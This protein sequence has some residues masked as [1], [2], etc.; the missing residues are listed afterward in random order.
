MKKL[1]VYDFPTRVFHWCF[2]GLFVSAFFIAKNIDDD[3]PLYPYHML[4]GISL[5]A[6]VLLRFIWGIWGSKHAKFTDFDLSP[7]NLMG[8]L[9]GILKGDK[10]TWPGHNPASSWAALMMILFALGSSLTG[11]L[12]TSG[13]PKENIEEIHEICANSFAVVALLHVAGILMHSLRHREMIG[14]S[15]MSGRKAQVTE[16]QEIHSQYWGVGAA[17]IIIMLGM[18]VALFKN[19]DASS[20]KLELFGT[21]LVLGETTEP[22]DD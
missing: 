19:Y 5:G 17:L 2:S 13:Y 11:I 15:M 14:W 10:K 20:G 7:K 22:K 9:V 18:G 8:Y 4:I 1:L 21:S 12:M 16:D 6:L 3:S